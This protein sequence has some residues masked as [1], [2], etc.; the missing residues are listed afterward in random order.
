MVIGYWLLVI[1]YRLLDHCHW[2]L[3]ERMSSRRI[4]P[5]HGSTERPSEIYK[6]R[7]QYPQRVV[8]KLPSLIEHSAGDQSFI[9]RGDQMASTSQQEPRALLQNLALSA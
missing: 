7:I 2:V 5:A 6:I 3:T 9:A 1:G 4:P 8:N